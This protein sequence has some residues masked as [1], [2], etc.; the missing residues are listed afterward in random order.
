MKNAWASGAPHP[1]VTYHPVSSASRGCEAQPAQRGDPRQRLIVADDSIGQTPSAL[2]RKAWRGRWR[3]VCAHRPPPPVKYVLLHGI[4]FSPAE[5]IANAAGNRGRDAGVRY[6]MPSGPT[7][8][9]TSRCGG[10]GARA[11]RLCTACF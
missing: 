5:L 11:R 7:R 9:D 2:V 6:G 4:D 3:S 8:W 10:R 1:A